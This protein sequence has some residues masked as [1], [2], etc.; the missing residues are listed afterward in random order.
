M[1]DY[2]L[3]LVARVLNAPLEGS[4]DGVVRRVSTDSRSVQQG[5]L[6]V[7]LSGERFDAHGF[8]AD[9]LR[10]G[11]VGAVVD[12]RR[13]PP[14]AA[15]A[16]PLIS[17]PDPLLALG[18]L[19]AWHRNRLQVRVVAVTG[20]VGKTTTKDFIASVL[21]RQWTTLKSPGNLN[22]E[23]GV[24]QTLLQLGPEHQ[25]AV[26]EMAM[27]GPGQ[28][29]YLARM[30]RPDVAVITNIGLS[31]MELL[32]SQ[33]AIASAKAEVL[34]YLPRGGTAVLNVDD[35]YFEF[36]KGRVPPG[37]GA[38]TFGIDRVK[39]DSVTGTYLG[40][41]PHAEEKNA[42]TVMGG[43]FTLRA[44]K[45]QSVR[46]VWVPLLG[47][48]NMRNAL[49]AAAAGQALGV[50]WPRICRGLGEAETSAMRMA[51]HRLRDGAFLLDDAYNASSPDAM[52]AA[53]DVLREM[54][55]LRKVAVLGSMLELG[56]ASE[57]AHRQVGEAAGALGPDLL[58]TVGEHA[59]L[60]AESARQAGMPAG[61]VI[62]CA[63]NDEALAELAPRRRP[64]DVILVKG[65]R[66]MAMEA[67]VSGL[68]ED[69]DR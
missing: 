37:A 31:H 11:A 47:K 33:D 9:A 42:P 48:H 24:A 61:T 4:G 60:I 5:D 25:A 20:S 34:D 65:S 15:K 18:D 36:L 28:I 29:R 32:G 69:G 30:A 35:G 66:G 8:V 1:L 59:A 27:R 21:A 57:A 51:V 12:P 53:L 10:K 41:A 63:G 56:Q 19:A 2:P 46:W 45:G 50:S 6:F 39:R 26:V 49:A 67:L 55:G 40:P 3:S 54:P 58:V 64:G 38:L 16:G 68:R 43:R 7:A 22:A 14:D 52:L 23:I 44:A 62:S 17:V 13:A